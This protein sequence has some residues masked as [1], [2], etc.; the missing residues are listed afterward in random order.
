MKLLLAM[1][2]RLDLGCIALTVNRWLLLWKCTLTILEAVCF[3]GCRSLVLNWADTF[4]LD[5]TTSLL[6]L[7]IR[8]VDINLLLLPRPTVTSLLA[9]PALHLASVAPPIKL[10]PAVSIRHGV[11][12]QLPSV[13]IFVT[14]LL[15]R[16]VSRPVMR[17]FPVLCVALGSTQVP[18]WQIWL[19]PAKN[20]T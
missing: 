20:R 4:P 2:I 17:P 13:S 11:R 18:A 5:I 14:P 7:L 16:N 9:W 15:G 8:C 10:L 3:T 1:A 12:L 19:R 6:V